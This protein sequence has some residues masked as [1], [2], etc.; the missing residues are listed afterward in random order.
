MGKY[1]GPVRISGTFADATLCSDGT[2]RNKSTLTK[3]R[4]KQSPDFENSRACAKSFGGASA[5]AA[6][7]FGRLP[8]EMRQQARGHA[9]NHIAKRIRHET[10]T[11]RSAAERYT[12][13]MALPALHQ[14]D[15]SSAHHLAN[16]VSIQTIGHPLQPK[17][18]HIQ[19]LKQAASRIIPAPDHHLQLRLHFG[20]IE[21]AEVECIQGGRWQTVQA[22][23]AH[24]QPATA[25]IDP[26]MIPDEGIAMSLQNPDPANPQVLFCAVE[27]RQTAPGKRPTKILSADTHGGIIRVAALYRAQAAMHLPVPAY[28]QRPAQRSYKRAAKH[29]HRTKITA[30]LKY[31]LAF[32][33]LAPQSPAIPQPIHIGYAPRLLHPSKRSSNPQRPPQPRIPTKSQA[34]VPKP[35]VQSQAKASPHLALLHTKSTH[36]PHILRKSNH[37]STDRSRPV[38]TGP[39]ISPTQNP[40]Q[41]IPIPVNSLIRYGFLS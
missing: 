9:H 35:Q 7:L 24:D 29:K 27:W 1:T 6:K 3:K 12:F 32:P 16:Q 36:T 20:F 14:L 4:W 41:K 30:T 13:E 17:G 33:R 18:I 26:A 5:C 38:R 28:M 10:N 2:A 21:F 25:W 37:P 39:P 15:L 40:L 8:D 22:T 19:G 23:D 31:R 11:L 34:P